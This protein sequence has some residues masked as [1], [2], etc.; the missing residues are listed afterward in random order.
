MTNG[1]YGRF[2]LGTAMIAAFVFVLS[3]AF[4][5]PAVFRFRVAA[6]LARPVEAIRVGMGSTVISMTTFSSM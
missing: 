4:V 6:T 1:N 3:I 5:P 2:L